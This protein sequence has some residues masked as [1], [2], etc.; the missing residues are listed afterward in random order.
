MPMKVIAFH[1]TDVCNLCLFRRRVV[2]VNLCWWDLRCGFGFA[3]RKLGG[4]LVVL[5]ASAWCYRFASVAPVRG[6]TLVLP[7]A[8]WVVCLWF[9]W[10]PRFVSVFQ[11]LPLCGAALW[12][13]LAQ[14]G[15]FAC[16]FA[17]IRDLL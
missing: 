17:G 10:H 7:G 15:R 16:G 5:L 2:T 9:C 14:A 4:L 12:V 6:G 11:A 1:A 3:G 13:C 8:S